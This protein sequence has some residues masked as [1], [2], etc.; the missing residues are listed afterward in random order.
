[1]SDRADPDDGDFGGDPQ[2]GVEIVECLS[3]EETGN[4]ALV[5]R[6][7]EDRHHRGACVDPPEGDLPVSLGRSGAVYTR[8][9][10]LGIAIQVR[11]LF[12][13]NDD[14]DG[15][16]RYPRIESL[17]NVVRLSCGSSHLGSQR[18]IGDD[19]EALAL[20]EARRRRSHRGV[21]DPPDRVV[22]DRFVG[23][24]PHHPPASDDVSEFHQSRLSA[25]S[26]SSIACLASPKYINV[27]SS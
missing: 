19:H 10:G 20:A 2:G 3:A 16:P 25:D 17:S 5:N 21:D 1:M 9:V 11:L 6:G 15:R 7:V 8:L 26:A 23:V 27:P 24:V 12:Y 14:V 18:G 22:F 13:A 4:E